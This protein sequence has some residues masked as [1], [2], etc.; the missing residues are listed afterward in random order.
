MVFLPPK[1]RA[2]P[3]NSPSVPPKVAKTAISGGL[4]SPEPPR[5]NKILASGIG[6]K[7]EAAPSKLIMKT[8]K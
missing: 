8:P 4:K 5:A 2:Y 1:P 7:I 6:K 3:E